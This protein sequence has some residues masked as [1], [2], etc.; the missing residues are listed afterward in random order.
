[1]R[2]R[3]TSR[4]ILIDPLGRVLLMRFKD[5]H[6]ERYFGATIGGGAEPGESPLETALRETQEETGFADLEPGPIV[7]MAS[8]SCPDSMVSPCSCKRPMSS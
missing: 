7:G 6:E 8:R 2:T 3:S 4:V 1:M 5:F